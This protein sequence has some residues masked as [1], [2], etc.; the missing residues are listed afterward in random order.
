[1]DGNKLEMAAAAAMKQNP[2]GCIVGVGKTTL[3]ALFWTDRQVDEGILF[4]N[5]ISGLAHQAIQGG[6]LTKKQIIE[7]LK[8]TLS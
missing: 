4:Q 8:R 6:R 7:N 2:T 1:M 3:N 5:L